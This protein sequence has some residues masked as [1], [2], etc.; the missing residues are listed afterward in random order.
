MAALFYLFDPGL[1]LYPAAKI[2]AKNVIMT[3]ITKNKLML[4]KASFKNLFIQYIDISIF[5]IA[6]LKKM[7]RAIFFITS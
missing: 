2:A 5:I 4:C 7:K 6:Y 1:S 3:K